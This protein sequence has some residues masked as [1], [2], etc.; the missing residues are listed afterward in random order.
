[1]QATTINNKGKNEKNKKV[2]AGP[3]VFPFKYKWKTHDECV[4]TEKG[5]ICATEVNKNRTLVYYEISST[6]FI[7]P[8]LSI[9]YRITG[10]S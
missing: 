4:E 3:C 8:F 1:M 9:L 7:C 5:Q 2:K 10:M 6:G